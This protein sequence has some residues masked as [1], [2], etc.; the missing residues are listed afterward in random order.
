VSLLAVGSV[1]L[2]TIETPTG[3]REEILGGSC[4][5]FSLSASHFTPVQIVAVVG[6][7][8]PEGHV[9]LLASKG[10]DTGGLERAEG[11]TFRWSGRYSQTLAERTTLDTQLNVFAGFAPKLSERHKQARLV[12]LG[13]IDPALQRGVLDQVDRPALVAMDTMNFWIEGSNASLKETLARV[14]VLVINEEEIRQL[15]GEHNVVRAATA[16]RAMGPRSVV[17]KR[18]EY[19]AILFD[20]AQTF[21]VTAYPLSDV[22]DPTGAGDSFAGGFMGSLAR[23]KQLDAAAFRRA[24]VMGTVLGSFS[25]EGFGVERLRTLTT[26]EVE[27][28]YHAYAKLTRVEGIE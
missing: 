15:A 16:V 11:R 3:R 23:E 24:M 19:G 13:N 21:A 12:F 6:T 9:D 26:P 20:P 18:G 17:V 1:A 28:R 14:D 8:F 25:V 22:V 5:F 2:D 4:T 27:G 7:D 10:V